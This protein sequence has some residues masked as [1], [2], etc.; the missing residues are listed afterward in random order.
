M[1]SLTQTNLPA[2]AATQALQIYLEATE[3][4]MPE[5]YPA[6]VSQIS[7]GLKT[8]LGGSWDIYSTSSFFTYSLL[9]MSYVAVAGPRWNALLC[10]VQPSLQQAPQCDE[11]SP[12]SNGT[13]S[14]R[15]YIQSGFDRGLTYEARRDNIELKLEKHGGALVGEDVNPP[16]GTRWWSAEEKQKAALMMT[17]HERIAR[18]VIQQA[19]DEAD[20]T[21]KLAAVLRRRLEDTFR[22]QPCFPRRGGSCHDEGCLWSVLVE[23]GPVGLQ[24]SSASEQ[25][26]FKSPPTGLT[27]ILHHRECCTSTVPTDEKDGEGAGMPRETIID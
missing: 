3:G 18:H 4:V 16:P 20:F 14:P 13:M 24:M 22:G 26:V 11:L 2:D 19:T 12:H 27:V 1:V 9:C 7:S 10:Q 15:D 21:P 23:L 17:K 8:Q 25:I 6:V 5:Q